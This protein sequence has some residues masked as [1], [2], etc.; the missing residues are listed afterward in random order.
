LGDGLSVW[1]TISDVWVDVLKHVKSSLVDSK[2]NGVVNLS[3]SE[4]SQDSLGSWVNVVNTS[5]S[6]NKENLGFSWNQEGVAGSG[7]S[8][9]L[10]QLNLSVSLSFNV[11][12]SSLGIL[13][14][15]SL[16]LSLSLSTELSS[17]GL[18]SSNSLALLLEVFR[19]DSFSSGGS[20]GGSWLS[21]S[22]RLSGTL[23]FDVHLKNIS[24]LLSI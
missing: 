23:L 17:L 7:L 13:S 20:S 18:L 24:C 16:T 2:E 5:N 9:L 15:L 10:N 3:K 14:L 21:V 1:V 19:D 12:L 8:S 4:E 11:T 6:D 22:S